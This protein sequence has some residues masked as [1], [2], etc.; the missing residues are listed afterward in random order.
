MKVKAHSLMIG[1]KE[2]EGKIDK[3]TSPPVLTL[4]DLGP[5]SPL[6]FIKQGFKLLEA[7][8]QEVAALKGLGYR[9]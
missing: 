6:E 8:P 5:V 9:I 4:N 7:T 1:Y 3:R 2:F